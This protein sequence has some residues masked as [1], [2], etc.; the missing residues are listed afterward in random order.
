MIVNELG[1]AARFLA[2][3][4]AVGALSASLWCAGLPLPAVQASDGASDPIEW[5]LAE[6]SADWDVQ[7]S[8][9]EGAGE[10]Y[11]EWHLE[12]RQL[13]H[14]ITLYHT[15]DGLWFVETWWGFVFDH[16]RLPDEIAALVS[17]PDPE[18]GLPPSCFAGPVAALTC[19]AI[20]LVAI[21]SCRLVHCE[22]TLPTPPSN[23][24]GG[25]DPPPPPPGDGG[26]GGGDGTGG[27]GGG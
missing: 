11:G 10:F 24:P 9:D 3:A 16:G 18:Q 21:A 2:R 15:P 13:P 23:P 20:V 25:D 8:Y 17:N 12:H 14:G 1:A 5:A 22:G 6:V 7:V 19:A 26:T 27:T 4:G